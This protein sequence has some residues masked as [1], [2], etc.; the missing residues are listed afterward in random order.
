MRYT[1]KTDRLASKRQKSAL[2]IHCFDVI[3]FLIINQCTLYVPYDRNVR[4]T[5]WTISCRKSTS[6]FLEKIVENQECTVLRK[7]KKRYFSP[8]V[9]FAVV[10]VVLICFSFHRDGFALSFVLKERVFGTRNCLFVYH[11]LPC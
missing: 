7:I 3:V 11:A 10:V 4:V 2:K 1:Q 5:I 9:F 6:F 8:A